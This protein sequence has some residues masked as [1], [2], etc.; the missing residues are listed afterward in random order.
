MM[1]E[2]GN[3]ELSILNTANYPQLGFT[4]IFPFMQ[5]NLLFQSLHP[6]L[7]FV[8]Q[9]SSEALYFQL[10]GDFWDRE[11]HSIHRIMNSQLYYLHTVNYCLA[12]HP[13][14]LPPRFLLLLL[15]PLHL[16]R[17]PLLLNSKLP[18]IVVNLLSFQVL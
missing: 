11:L 13:L 18:G 15:H 7:Q 5:E 17:C 10:H 12:H 1:M 16:L 9:Q 4:I 3:D 6:P 14:P 2:D 8:L